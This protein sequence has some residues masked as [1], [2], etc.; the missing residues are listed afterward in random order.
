MNLASSYNAPYYTTNFNFVGNYWRCKLRIRFII[1][2]PLNIIPNTMQTFI[3]SSSSSLSPSSSPQIINMALN[4]YNSTGSIVLAGIESFTY[5]AVDDINNPGI[6]WSINFV[7]P[8]LLQII[9]DEQFSRFDYN[10]FIINPFTE[11]KC[12]DPYYPIKRLGRN[13]NVVAC[14]DECYEDEFH[15]YL[16]LNQ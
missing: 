12:K 2:Y 8:S 9:L 13:T 15:D 16:P 5:D 10:I 4:F 1:I 11:M 7:S 6:Q 14:F 3:Y